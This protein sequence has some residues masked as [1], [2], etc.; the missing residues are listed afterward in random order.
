MVIVEHPN[1]LEEGVGLFRFEVDPAVEEDAGEVDF[2]NVAEGSN[3]D[4]VVGQKLCQLL[5]GLINERGSDLLVTI[6]ASE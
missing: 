6:L 2:F 4:V 1:E 5:I 3:G